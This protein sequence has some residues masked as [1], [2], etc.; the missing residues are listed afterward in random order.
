MQYP[1]KERVNQIHLGDPDY[2]LNV[3]AGKDTD[4]YPMVIDY[5]DLIITIEGKEYVWKCGKCNFMHPEQG[6][7]THHYDVTH[8]RLFLSLI[9][10]R[11]PF[12]FSPD[13]IEILDRVNP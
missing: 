8:G 2:Y 7:T 10:I 1:N 3:T 4:R 12:S 9:R 13:E 6:R 5:H 11:L